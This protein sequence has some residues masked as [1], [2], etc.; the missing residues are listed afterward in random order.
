MTKPRLQKQN[1][2]RSCCDV[3]QL[4]LATDLVGTWVVQRQELSVLDDE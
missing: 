4:L 1:L 3:K 2:L